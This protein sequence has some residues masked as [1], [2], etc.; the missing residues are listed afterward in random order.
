MLTNL[1]A[2]RR[3]LTLVSI[4]LMFTI[5]LLLLTLSVVQDVQARARA[6]E[7]LEMVV[8]QEEDTECTALLC[9]VGMVWVEGGGGCEV[10]PGYECCP[11]CTQE[12]ACVQS[13]GVHSHKCCQ[14]MGLLSS[15]YKLFC[16]EGWVWVEWKA[17]CYRV[18]DR[19]LR[20]V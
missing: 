6:E 5:S 12:Y 16:R 11:T 14:L 2:R 10:V 19:Q 4:P 17:Q 20:I 3:C 7:M 1:L 9:P 15:P 13:G 18:V 8:C